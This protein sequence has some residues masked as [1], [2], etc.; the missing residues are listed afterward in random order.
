MAQLRICTQKRGSMSKRYGIK[1][2]V[3]R[4]KDRRTHQPQKAAVRKVHVLA[5]SKRESQLPI[6]TIPSF[7]STY[8]RAAA[9]KFARDFWTRVCPDLHIGVAT[10]P[11][12]KSVPAGTVFERVSTGPNVTE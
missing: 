10:S 7:V 9:L 2:R 5:E 4:K 6:L 1:G 11:G 3:A 12:V 8:D